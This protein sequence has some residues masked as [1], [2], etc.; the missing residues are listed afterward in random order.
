MRKYLLL[1]VSVSCFAQFNPA[2]FYS[3][4]SFIKLSKSLV[5]YYKLDNNADDALSVNN[6]TNIGGVFTTG[7]INDGCNFNATNR[8]INVNDTDSF[9][10]VSGSSDLKMSINVWCKF[11]SVSGVNTIVTKRDSGTQGEW[12]F[13]YNSTFL[14]I[15]LCIPTAASFI[16]ANYTFTPTTGQWYMFTATYDGSKL[17]S[18]IKLYVNGALVSSTNSTTG[19]YTGM[20]NTTSKL[21]IGNSYLN[22]EQFKGTIDEVGIWKNRVL[23]PS[24]IN[25][26]YNSNSGLS[27]P[28]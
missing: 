11:D 19:S 9:S 17:S 25:K 18:G 27:Y 15:L 3:S 28:F 23:T 5:G 21:L 4:S 22:N 7:K 13:A 6:G 20:S 16:R 26:L 10:F 1:L 24:D 14:T 2:Q 8:V 12:I